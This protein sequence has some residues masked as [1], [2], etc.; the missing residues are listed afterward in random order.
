MKQIRIRVSNGHIDTIDKATNYKDLASHWADELGPR[1]PGRD[2]LIYAAMSNAMTKF[3]GVC[4]E[5]VGHSLTSPSFRLFS[6]DAPATLNYL[7]KVVLPSVYSL[8]DLFCNYYNTLKPDV[9]EDGAYIFENR[10]LQY[11]EK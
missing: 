7:E 11:K 2:V 9:L 4:P 6:V 1:Y 5:L 3:F 8:Y 10:D